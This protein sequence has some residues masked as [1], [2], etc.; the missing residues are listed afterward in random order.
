LISPTNVS[1]FSSK[2]ILA[3]TF[4]SEATQRYKSS[5]ETFFMQILPKLLQFEKSK[6]HQFRDTFVGQEL[7]ELIPLSS[8]K[9]MHEID[10]FIFDNLVHK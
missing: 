6:F 10:E 4:H 1:N 8:L 5:I 9:K 2:R 3:K 7:F